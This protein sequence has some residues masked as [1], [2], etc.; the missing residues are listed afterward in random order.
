MWPYT[1]IRFDAYDIIP[2]ACLVDTG[3]CDPFIRN[4][5]L[6]P[7]VVV[8][9]NGKSFIVCMISSGGK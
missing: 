6:P 9:R 8:I 3:G 1:S 2:A 5:R 4:D 7:D